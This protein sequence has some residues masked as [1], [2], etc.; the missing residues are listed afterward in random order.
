MCMLYA[1]RVLSDDGCRFLFSAFKTQQQINVVWRGRR[2]N[3]LFPRINKS[4]KHKFMAQL[5]A[6]THMPILIQLIVGQLQ[7]VEGHN[8]LHPIGAR[9]WRIRMHMYPR[10]RY[11]VRLARHHPARAAEETETPS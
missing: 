6:D 2:P 8:L 5:K 7:L 4:H 10:W 9:R 11:R 1:C 3:V